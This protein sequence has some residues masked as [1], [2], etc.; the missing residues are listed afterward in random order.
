MSQEK[1][2]TKMN[3]KAN[4]CDKKE[5]WWLIPQN[6]WSNFTFTFSHISHSLTTLLTIMVT[7]THLTLSRQNLLPNS[8]IKSKFQDK[9]VVCNSMIPKDFRRLYI[10]KCRFPVNGQRQF[11]ECICWQLIPYIR[12][13]YNG[14]DY[15][16]CLSLASHHC[17]KI[18][19]SHKLKTPH[20]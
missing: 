2:H 8:S 7:A 19:V 5:V 1:S 20:S 4:V 12:S 11:N 14:G 15:V 13:N 16:F 10:Q 6:L 9:I 3:N 18:V 17:W